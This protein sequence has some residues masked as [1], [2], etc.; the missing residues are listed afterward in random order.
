MGS[1]AEQH[2]HPDPLAGFAPATRAWFEAA[3]DGPTSAQAG[4]WAAIR[5]QNDVLVVAPTGSGKTLAAFLSAL[6]H[7]SSTPPPADPRRRLRVLYISPLKALAV[8]VERNLR[9]PLTGL[10][11]AAV[12]LGLPEPEVQVGIRSGDTPA[13]ERRKF[14]SHPPDILITTPESLFLLLTSASREALRGIDTVILDEV[15]A[16]AGTK[17]GAHLALSLERLD[18]LLER[19][20]RRIG[21]SATVRPVAEVA[22]FL[23][24]QR[25]AAIVQPPSAKRFDLSVVVPVAD[26]G[27]LSP[28][29]AQGPPG[30]P[31]GAAPPTASRIRPGPP[32][33]GRTSRSGSSIWCRRTARPSSSPTRAAWPSACATGSTRSPTSG[34]PAGRCPSRTPPPS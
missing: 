7:L 5:E 21:L 30:G 13:P 6:D 33:S 22:C 1:M 26:L 18:Q 29:P 25:E 19:P 28:S 3:F 8:D 24:P 31:R 20:A 27:E 15:H 14:Q 32:R 4:A 16:V 11:Q 10:R 34:P 9:A 23:S 17:R 12:R 2:P